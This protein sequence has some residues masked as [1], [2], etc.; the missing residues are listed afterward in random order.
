MCGSLARLAAC[1]STV[2]D[3]T[4]AEITTP[5]RGGTIRD[6]TIGEPPMLDMMATTAT[7][8]TTITTNI[9]E[10]LFT[11][12]SHLSPKPSL[13][14]SYQIEDRGLSWVIDLR[15]GVLVHNGQEMTSEDGPGGGST[16]G[17][18]SWCNNSP[19]SRTSANV[20]T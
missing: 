8:T 13:A 7:I 17:K 16:P 14:E 5:Q 20:W 2:I 10:G 12:D 3:T 11:L 1:T 9:Y 4:S 19:R 15:K 18:I 6:A